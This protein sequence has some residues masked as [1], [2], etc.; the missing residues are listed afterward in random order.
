MARIVVAEDCE[1]LRTVYATCL[2]AHGHDV[3]EACDG[4]EAVEL[5]HE[6]R[7]DL[8]LL[9]V[10][11]PRLNGFEVL[12]AL[13][14]APIATRLRA[15]MLT[16]LSDGDSRLGA[17]G[18]GAVDYLVKGGSLLELSDRVAAVLSSG[19]SQAAS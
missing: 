2:R 16:V 11:M 10:W 13:R 15:V 8:I 6:H 5:V 17:F 7:P 14:A 3:F 12:E 1:D 4:H 19:P 9:D 18:A